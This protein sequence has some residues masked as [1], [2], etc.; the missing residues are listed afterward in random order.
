MIWLLAVALL[1]VSDAQSPVPALEAAVD[2][3]RNT[4]LIGF[5]TVGSDKCILLNE[6]NF[7]VSLAIG[8]LSSLV[9]LTSL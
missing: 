4:F 8:S 6:M 5:N 1:A 7:C 2:Q 9:S 3:C